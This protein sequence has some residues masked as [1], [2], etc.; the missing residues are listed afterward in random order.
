MDGVL[1]ARGVVEGIILET[2]TAAARHDRRVVADAVGDRQR[3]RVD[4]HLQDAV[5]EGEGGDVDVRIVPGETITGV[6]T[7]FAELRSDRTGVGGAQ[8]LQAEAAGT[9]VGDRCGA[10]HA[11][12]RAKA[13][14][15]RTAHGKRG[16]EIP[17]A[18]QVEGSRQVILYARGAG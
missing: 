4:E 6:D 17:G 13:D 7:D 14:E 15:T 5:P 18:V 10:D 12:S 11:R 1:S 16:V 2:D 3:A 9:V 8:P